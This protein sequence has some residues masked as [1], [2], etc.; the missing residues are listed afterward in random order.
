M[1]EERMD[2][3]QKLVLREKQL[4]VTRRA[5]RNMHKDVDGRFEEAG[6]RVERAGWKKVV[7]RVRR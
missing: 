7:W 6:G 4:P 2:R 3:A 5:V 1:G